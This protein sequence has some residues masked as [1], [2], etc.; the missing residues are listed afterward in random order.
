MLSP[1]NSGLQKPRSGKIAYDKLQSSD[2]DPSSEQH[3]P[4]FFG[5]KKPANFIPQTEMH[6]ERMRDFSKDTNFWIGDKQ[7]LGS[8][9]ESPLELVSVSGKLDINEAGR[10]DREMRMKTMTNFLSSGTISGLLESQTVRIYP[11]ASPHF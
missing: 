9:K 3:F 10:D 4:N 2:F 6:Q 7:V 11:Y 1:R 5:K 8:S